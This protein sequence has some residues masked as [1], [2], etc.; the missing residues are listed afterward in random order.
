MFAAIAT[1]RPPRLE[2][3]DTCD[4]D[5]LRSAAQLLIFA[6][7]DAVSPDVRTA[8]EGVFGGLGIRHMYRPGE[9]VSFDGR[10][11]ETLDAVEIGDQVVVQ[12][13]GWALKT[14][15]GTVML[16]KSVVSRS[17]A[18]ASPADTGTADA[19]SSQG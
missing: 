15:R 11:H 13:P 8:L 12:E 9:T 5:F 2:P 3:E 7:Q 10:H 6:W 19:P 4:Y 16:T 17:P 18:F 1:T 14:H